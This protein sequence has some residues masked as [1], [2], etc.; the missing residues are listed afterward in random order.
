MNLMT[1]M[2]QF[3]THESCVAHLEYLRW[4]DNPQC[5]RCESENVAR[6]TIRG[7][8]GEWNCHLCK[9]TFNVMTNTMFQGT[10]V[11]LQKWFLAIALMA[12]AKKSL[13]SPQLARDLGLTQPTALF[14]QHRIRAEMGRK[15][16]PL[17]KGIIEA[18]ESWIG[19][20]PRKR[21]KRNDDEP[22]AK[23]G[24]GTDK[25]PII[26]A[27]ERGGAVTVRV[28]TVLSGRGIIRYLKGKINPEDSKLITDEYG[29]YRAIRPYIPHEVINHQVQYVD[30][31]IHTNTIEGFWS[32]LKRAWYGSH[33]HYIKKMTPLFVIEAC[34]KYNHRNVGN[35]FDM[36][37]RGCFA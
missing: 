12:N 27:V 15:E 8:T 19:G 34:W 36:F 5:P 2:E 9:S 25:T 30:G 33:H 14:M 16:S 3:P 22:P 32:L 10:Q 21:N 17:L 7:K 4:K 31:D 6:K 29:A 24:R 20:K 1:L 37:L 23:R 13:S 35:A 18:D 26:G 11:P 28:Q